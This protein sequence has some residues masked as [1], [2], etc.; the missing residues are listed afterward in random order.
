MLKAVDWNDRDAAQQGTRGEKKKEG[1]KG[2]KKGKGKGGKKRENLPYLPA[3][4]ILKT[5]ERRYSC[6]RTMCS[7]SCEK[8][9]TP[10][11]ALWLLS[12]VGF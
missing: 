2:K 11:D 3:L 12:E 7:R 4:E 10:A 6:W 8:S 9:L 5:P 1:K